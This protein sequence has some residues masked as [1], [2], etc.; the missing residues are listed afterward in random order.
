[1]LKIN[2]I[3]KRRYPVNAKDIEKIVK[4]SAKKVKKITGEIEIILVSDSEIKKLNK[5]WR[6]INRPTDVL[7]YAWTEDKKLKSYYLGQVF[8]SYPRIKSQAKEYRFSIEHEFARI[9]VH[10]LLHL[11]GFD[12]EKKIEAK[13][14][15]VLQEEIVDS[16]F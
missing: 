14:M 4:S 3:N 15:F 6:N 1:M 5:I 12:H 10:G 13:R 8:I 7:A 11:A 2:L 16:L 9:L